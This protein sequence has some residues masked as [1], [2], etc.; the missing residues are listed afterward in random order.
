MPSVGEFELH[1]DSKGSITFTKT[2]DDD[3]PFVVQ[4]SFGGD[5]PSECFFRPEDR[6]R[7]LLPF[8]SVLSELTVPRSQQILLRFPVDD[9]DSVL[10]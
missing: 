10:W 3:S 5:V 7:C 9:A 8:G 2:S 1:A 6:M 4:I